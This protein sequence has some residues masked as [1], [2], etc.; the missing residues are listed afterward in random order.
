MRASR[1]Y[2]TPRA[3][4]LAALVAWPLL[5]TTGVARADNGTSHKLKDIQNRIQTVTRELEK[6]QGQRGRVEAQLRRSEQAIGAAEQALR[7]TRAKLSG[8]QARLGTLMARANR[9]QAR[10]KKQIEAL[11]AQV[12]SAYKAG[13]QPRLQLLLNQEDPAR[14]SRM[15]TYYDYLNRARMR[16]IASARQH[17][18]GLIKTQQALK[19]ETRALNATLAQQRQHQTELAQAERQRRLA[20]AQ[21]DRS[22]S[23]KKA[24]LAN[25]KQN[26]KRL[27]DVVDS[28]N[29]AVASSA[30]INALDHAPFDTLRGRLPWPVAGSIAARYGEPRDG[31]DGALRWQGTFISAKPGT[32]IRAVDAGRVVFADWLRGYG[33]L[34]I[35][36]HG[37]GYMTL[38]GH[39]QAIYRPVGAWVRAGEVVASVGDSGGVRSSGLYFAIRRNGRPLNP[40]RWCSG[41]P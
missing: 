38:Y 11:S 2:T 32:P 36:D 25:L 10:L 35:I 28:I 40:E 26:A 4:A 16:E 17:L 22:I 23:D 29:R 24:H 8:Q 30:S 20:L 3:A 37:K 14:L 5:A 41:H 27:Q 9:Q 13:R 15:L 7:Q 1:F 31:S 33:L 6:A 39:D 21:L 19:A 34:L 12:V 18:A